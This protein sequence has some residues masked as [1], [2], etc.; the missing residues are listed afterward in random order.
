M[1]ARRMVVKSHVPHPSSEETPVIPCSKTFWMEQ[2][3]VV[4]ENATMA[5]AKALALVRKFRIS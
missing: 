5:S 1:L 4:E 2:H 3:V